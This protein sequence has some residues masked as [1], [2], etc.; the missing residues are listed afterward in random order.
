M[1]FGAGSIGSHVIASL[2]RS[3]VGLLRVIDF[4]VISVSSLNH[5]AF[6]TRKNVG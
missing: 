4:D 1:V 2:S 5:H 3:G 6:A